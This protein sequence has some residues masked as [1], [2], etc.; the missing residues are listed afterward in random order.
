M[1]LGRG[2]CLLVVLGAV[3]LLSGLFGCRTVDTWG[4]L[5]E[6]YE[7]EVLDE[8]PVEVVV[9]VAL[10]IVTD[11]TPDNR[12]AALFLAQTIKEASG[13]Q[14][15]VFVE[16]PGQRCAV[17]N[18]LCVGA[19]SANSGWACALTNESAEAFR[20][21]V[22]DGSVRF[23]GKAD[24]AVFDWCERMLGMRY[25]P[26]FGKS[27]GL[28]TNIVV[29]ASDYSDMPVYAYRKIGGNSAAPWQKIS[30]CGG[31]HLTGVSVHQPHGWITNATL[32]AQLPEIFENGETPMLCYGDPRT[33]EYYKR[34]VDRH[35]AGVED[36][37]GIVD[38]NR[39]V[40][41]V[42][43]W[44]APLRCACR[45]C[46]AL[47]APDR[48]K[49]GSASPI[50]WGHF[51]AAL[52]DWLKTAHPDYRIS[53]LPYMNTCEV[54]ANLRSRM[55]RRGRPLL[56]AEAEVCTM[57]GLALLK[58]RACKDREERIIRDWSLV[59]GCKVLNWHYGCWPLEW[60]AA[61]YVFGKTIR[62]HY[63]DM[64]D[65]QC[66]SFV[67]GSGDDPRMALSAY[68]WMRCLWN[69]EIDVDAVY[70]EFAL[71][72]FGPAALPMR[73]LIAL[74]EACWNR[75]WDSDECSF[76]NVFEVSY[77]RQDVERMKL[78]VRAADEMAAADDNKVAASL[79]RWYASAFEEFVAESD[80]LSQ[81]QGRMAIRP[82]V[83]REM[84]MANSALYPKPWTPTVVETKVEDDELCLQVRCEDPAAPQMDFT[85]TVNDVV[86]GN[87]CVTFVMVE[88][89]DTHLAQVNLTG[90]IKK[91]WNGFTA[92]VASDAKGWTVQARLRLSAEMRQAGK[93]LGNVARWRVGDRRLPHDK[94]VPGSRYE[95]SRLCTCYTNIDTDPAALVEFILTPSHDN[96]DTKPL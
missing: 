50:I 95:Q 33:L 46:N 6:P 4:D 31:T 48:G 70:D 29:S 42:C 56:N 85:R 45:W 76:H 36:S 61:P 75:Q 68:V 88:G 25:Y 74:Q 44:D 53:F 10:P 96:L 3:G 81:R 62:E 52:S 69:P 87:D 24:F 72:V 32:K 49:A 57:P 80:E 21:V 14:P 8:S 38:T 73:Q 19:V 27:V 35:I 83:P 58:N 47:Y 17:S 60:T 7:W 43:Q 22:R 82:G 40:V 37:G 2:R 28:Q 12:W 16:R 11:D 79:V 63:A 41:T 13:K 59:T 84:V 66:G 5:N 18:A 30:R 94:R 92:S 91:G 93:V 39:K 77:P 1:L 90:E 89:E 71:R 64:A 54:P 67:C 78:L 23:L 86:W 51:L 65:C 20:V 34:R 55:R 15:E 9:D 26:C